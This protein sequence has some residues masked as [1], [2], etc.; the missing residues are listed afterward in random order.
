[1]SKDILQFARALDFAAKKHI[2]QRR[3]GELEEPYINHL[4]D[5]ARLLA[6]ATEGGDV[7]LVLAGLLHDT[8]EDTKTTFVE[9]EAEFGHE[10]AELV[11]EVSDDKTLD[12]AERKRLQIKKAPAKSDR[13]KM[14][15]L[16]D[17]TSNLHSIIHSPPVDW[18]LE[19]KR[20]YFKWA[21]EVVEG[22]RGV[23]EYLE[24]EFD[25]TWRRGMDMLDEET[26]PEP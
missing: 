6:A 11:A 12:K 14:L 4:A 17:K 8:I 7:V 25:R 13:A 20:E 9:L 16:A 21:G 24:K 23:N 19:R 18:S 3:K 2:H 1:M 15:K 26:C 5:V 22:C 10:V